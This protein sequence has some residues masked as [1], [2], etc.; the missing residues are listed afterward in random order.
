VRTPVG[1]EEHFRDATNVSV[2]R[3]GSSATRGRERRVGVFFEVE[4]KEPVALRVP[5]L[6]H[7]SHFGLGLFQP[8]MSLGTAQLKEGVS[9]KS[10]R[11]QSR[12]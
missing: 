3:P 1:E 8:I 11:N 12:L 10:T 2:H 9:D 7:S 5:T 6:G 4:F